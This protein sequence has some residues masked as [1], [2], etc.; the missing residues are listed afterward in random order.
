MFKR[1]P[2]F[3]YKTILSLFFLLAISPIS[4]ISA[5]PNYYYSAINYKKYQSLGELP[6]NEQTEKIEAYLQKQVPGLSA[7]YQDVINAIIAEGHDVYL[8]GGVVRDLLSLSEAEPNDVDLDYTATVEEL[9]AI[10]EKNHWQYTHFPNRLVVT[11]GDH[12]GGAIDAMPVRCDEETDSEASLEFTINNIF[13]HC[14]TKSFLRSSEVGLIDLSYDRIHILTDNWELWLKES[15]AHPYYKIIR[16]WK[17][18]G[19]GYVYSKKL[20]DF[21][22]SETNKILTRDSKGFQKD[23]FHYVS[24]HHYSYQDIYH[25]AVA[26][27]GYEW[28][29]NNVSCNSD[30]ISNLYLKA[31]AEKDKYTL[32]P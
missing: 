30:Y 11:I 19:K 29:Q 21:F 9:I 6:G 32:H 18:V 27:M 1:P 15:N 16:F 22:F 13:Y 2:S 14:N 17:M 12:R 28:A 20:Q 5:A 8:R 7:S 3:Y 31:E 24:H 25:G 23:L 26:I 10:C 4:K